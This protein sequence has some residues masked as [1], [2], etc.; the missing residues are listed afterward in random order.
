MDCIAEWIGR[1][2][3][4]APGIE[5]GYDRL[6]DGGRGGRP[7]GDKDVEVELVGLSHE[8]DGNP[9]RQVLLCPRSYKGSPTSE[10]PVNR[11][12]VDV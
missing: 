8:G 5:G 9:R 1:E 2:A 6:H 3:L 12:V 7:V 11:E 4:P 10:R